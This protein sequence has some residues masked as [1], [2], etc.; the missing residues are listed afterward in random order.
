MNKITK[1]F[2]T[3]LITLSILIVNSQNIQAF[4]PPTCTGPNGTTGIDTAIGCIP[5]DNTNEFASFVL[6]WAVGIGGGVSFLLIVYG[7][8]LITTSQ[9]NPERLKGGQDILNGAIM[10]LIMLVFSVFLLKIIGI[11]ILQLP[12]IS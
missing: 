3:F 4:T 6:R 10:G 1:I 11:D 8:F 5:V 9:G 7:G 2:L 12:G